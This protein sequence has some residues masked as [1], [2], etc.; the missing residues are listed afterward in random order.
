MKRIKKQVDSLAKEKKAKETTLHR[1]SARANYLS[2][3]ALQEAQDVIAEKEAEI[4]AINEQIE[5]LQE[6]DE[7]EDENLRAA[8]QELQDKVKEVEESLNGRTV[9]IRI[10]NF[11]KTKKSVREFMKTVRN[12]RDRAEFVQNWKACLVKN[13]VYQLP[14]PKTEEEEDGSLEDFNL[15]IPQPVLDEITDMWGTEADNFLQLLDITGLKA[16]KT[17]VEVGKGPHSRAKGHRRGEAKTEQ[18]LVFIQKEI[19]A[20]I[21][22]K[23]IRLD[24]EMMEYEDEGGALMQYITRELSYRILHEIM[25]AVLV[26]DGRNGNE[27][28]EKQHPDNSITKIEAVVDAGQP[29]ATE[30]ESSVLLGTPG[31]E[32]GDPGEVKETFKGI[33]ECLQLANL[34]PPTIDEVVNALSTI[35]AEGEVTLFLSKM[36][37]NSL[38]RF[39]YS[40]DGTPIFLS[41]EELADRLGVARIITTHLLPHITYKQETDENGGKI[42]SI[43]ALVGKA[44]KLVG[45]LTIRGFENFN[46]TFNKN[47]Y[48]NEVYVGGALAV[49]HSA[50]FITQLCHPEK[51]EE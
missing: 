26:G 44:Y 7:D 8:L 12:S 36:A 24:R 15:L 18:K 41:M 31:S 5:A 45:D 30:Y 51:V 2:D 29:W 19:R 34:T 6:T 22:Y 49:P 43:I 32:E 33:A 47:E 28:E 9:Q 1:L 23:F 48:L 14:Y 25:R 13:G 20:Q 16:Y 39:V 38:R 50:V 27:E 17:L 10:G 37:A 46:L 11:L 40:A 3:E 42:V 21:I 4:A 35:E